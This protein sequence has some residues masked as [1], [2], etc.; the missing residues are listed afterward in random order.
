MPSF[1]HLWRI[2]HEKRRRMKNSWRSCTRCTRK[3]T[4]VWTSQP[5]SSYFSY[6]HWRKCS[7]SQWMTIFWM[8]CDT[9]QLRNQAGYL[10]TNAYYCQI[11][12]WNFKFMLQYGSRSWKDYEKQT[13]SRSNRM[14]LL[15]V[16]FNSWAGYKSPPRHNNP[17]CN[18]QWN[19]WCYNPTKSTF[20]WA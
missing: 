14:H 17:Y 12:S 3:V 7:G 13:P 2:L 1:C 16:H 6:K 20:D 4:V 18:W 10:W 9:L 15:I 8:S 5:L 19:F 11:S